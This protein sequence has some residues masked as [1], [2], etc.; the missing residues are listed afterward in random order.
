MRRLSLVLLGVIVPAML[1][2]Q[3]SSVP[4]RGRGRAGPQRPAEKPPQAP[5]IHDARLYNR[6]RF[7]RFSVESSPMASYFQTSGLLAPNIPEDYMTVGDA[8]I[9]TMRALPSLYLAG[10]FTAAAAGAPF[11][12]NSSEFGIRIKPWTAPRVS[13][14]VDAR[15]SWAFTSNFGLPSSAVPFAQIYR[16]AYGDF[17]TGYGHGMVLGLGVDTRLTARYSVMASLSNTHYAMTGR[18]ITSTNRWNYTNE[19][20]R[21]MVGVRYNHGRWLDA[22]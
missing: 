10:A 13:P 3:V 12:M 11:S 8:T 14:F 5:G 16:N 7:S 1:S 20:T 15:A 4:V 22:P 17:S 6:Y 2:A 9:I 21:L 18:S 19:A